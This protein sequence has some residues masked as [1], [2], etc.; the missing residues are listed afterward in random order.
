MANSSSNSDI[1]NSDSSD[2]DLPRVGD[3][4]QRSATQTS[5]LVRGD[6]RYKPQAAKDPFRRKVRP[7]GCP[8]RGVATQA[9]RP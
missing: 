7:L 3:R 6:G 9:S 5:T 4:R 8:A 2:S 1:S